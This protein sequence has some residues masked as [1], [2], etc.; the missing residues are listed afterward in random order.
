MMTRYDFETMTDRRGHDAIAVDLQENDFW[1]LPQG[2]T[3]PGFDKIPL[4]IADM[5][6]P[7]APCVTERIMQRASHPIYGYFLP[8]EEYFD[9]II[10]W[11]KESFGV[12]DLARQNIGY[13]N[14]V[15]GGITSALQVLNPEH[16]E[17][18][19]HSPTYTG[20]TTQLERNGYP[21][22]LSPLR[23]DETGVLRMDYDDMERQIREK[24]I[25]TALLCSPHNPSGRVWQR[26]ELERAMDLFQKY[27]V[28]VIADE[29][30]SDLTLFGNRHI[31][32]QSVSEAAKQRTIAFYAPSKTFNLAG[33]VGSYHVVYNQKLA[34]QLRAYEVKCHYNEMNVLSMHALI[35]AYTSEGRAWMEQ[36]KRVLETNVSLTEAFFREQAEGVTL[37][38]PEGTYV[39]VPD[40]AEWCRIH[41]KSLDEL[42]RSGVEAGVLWRDG[43]QFHIPHGIRM[44]LG[45][46]TKLLEEALRRLKEYVL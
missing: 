40:F 8:S 32:V 33:L 37:K 6:F 27:E 7:T 22:A 43:R 24:H 11:Q 3:K 30:W 1:A 21:A 31:P 12:T 28:N 25:H 2:E 23:E 36:L 46:Q 26:W 10:R 20:F 41:E 39:V 19:V 13:E 35:G 34:D 29:I 42:L 45:V 44:A 18:L 4:W 38:K 14:G 5:N 17:V 9:A 15:L 16:A